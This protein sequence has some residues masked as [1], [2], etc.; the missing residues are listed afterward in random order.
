MSKIESEGVDLNY[1]PLNNFLID[2]EKVSYKDLERKLYDNDFIDKFQA[3]DV[4]VS[5]VNPENAE[6]LKYLEDLAQR[7][8]ESGGRWGD[9]AESTLAGGL[10]QLVAGSLELIEGANA[11]ALDAF[12]GVIVKPFSEA[13]GGEEIEYGRN[14]EEYMKYGSYYGKKVKDYAKEIREETR[15]YQEGSITKSMLKGDWGNAFFSGR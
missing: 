2:G 13:L 6:S 15:A 5:I 3:G 12:E 11:L 9:I 8:I 7:Q 14:F 4:D 1:I 10:D